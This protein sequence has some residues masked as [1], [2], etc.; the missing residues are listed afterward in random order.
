MPVAMTYHCEVILEADTLF[1]TGDL[2][3]GDVAQRETFLYQNHS[4]N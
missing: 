2:Q 3:A 4:V 1:V